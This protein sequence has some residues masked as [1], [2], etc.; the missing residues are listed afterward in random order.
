MVK[1]IVSCDWGTSSFRARLVNTETGN[2]MAALEDGEGIAAVY[3]DWYQSGLPPGGRAGYFLERLLQKLDKLAA[4][5]SRDIPL[6]ISGMASSSIGMVELPYAQ[7]PFQLDGSNMV[8]K[9]IGSVGQ[10]GPVIYICSGVRGKQDAMRGEET[11]LLG[12]DFDS[13]GDTLAILPG[14]H[15][16]H[17]LVSRGEVR[18]I[19][20]YMT[21]EFFELLSTKSILSLSIRRPVDPD[22]SARPFREGVQD[23]FGGNLLHV[24]FQTRMRQLLNNYDAEQAYLYL[25]GVLLGAELQAVGE[26]K[27]PVCLVAGRH[28][29]RPYEAAVQ[30]VLGSVSIAI[31]D[32]DE[33]LVE[34][35]CR[36]ARQLC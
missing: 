28:L 31:K 7:L 4:P 11:M 35:H 10:D 29:V 25:N 6:L 21:G 23:G 34:G 2:V 14:T 36:L 15:S 17:A 1:Q 18:D 26:W 3:R 24:A 22:Y 16:K 12:C 27:K 8:V 30:A 20:T 33:A 19:S 13:A 5:L 9:Q 32:A